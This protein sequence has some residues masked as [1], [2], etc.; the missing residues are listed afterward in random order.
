M[1]IRK[2]LGA[3]NALKA[4]NVTF[5]TVQRV[6]EHLANAVT[7]LRKL[8]NVLVI[9]CHLIGETIVVVSNVQG[10]VTIIHGSQT[11][12]VIA[13]RIVITVRQMATSLP[14]P[15]LAKIQKYYPTKRFV[16]KKMI[17]M[18]VPQV[19]LRAAHVNGVQLI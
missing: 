10:T 2:M 16:I 3:V 12:A 11:K 19:I 18:Q 7:G 15:A 8:Q 9:S 17:P 5:V 1:T 6:R 14:L 4:T 13:V